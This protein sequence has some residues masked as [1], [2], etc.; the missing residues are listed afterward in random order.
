M[1][2]FK[3]PLAVYFVWHPAD[4]KVVKPLVDYCVDQFIRN[5]DNPFSRGI[6]LPIFLCSSRDGSTPNS[7]YDKAQK[8]IIVPFVGTEVV[9]DDNWKALYESL[10]NSDCISIIP[11]AIDC[12]GLNLGGRLHSL[13]CLRAKDWG[14][15]YVNEKAFIAIAHEIF[16]YSFSPLK[17][18]K[19]NGSE[20]SINL[21]ISHSKWGG[22]GEKVAREIKKFI[23]NSPMQSFFDAYEI[24]PGQRFDDSIVEKVK[25][26]TLIAIHTDSYSSRYW[27]QKEIM[28]AKESSRPIIAVDCQDKFEDRRFPHSSNIPSTHIHTAD[29]I[30]EH[31]VLQIL[32]SAILET[33]R[34]SYCL[35]LLEYYKKIGW[36]SADSTVLAKPLELTD[37]KKLKSDETLKEFVY[38]E[39]PLYPEEKEIIENLSAKSYTPLEVLAQG[40]SDLSVGISISESHQDDLL[41]YGIST[42]HLKILSQD[43]ARHLLARKAKLI[44]GGDLRKDGFTQ[45]IIEEAEALQI[46]LGSDDIYV[47]NYLAWPIY[48]S[49][50]PKV[51]CWKAQFHHI[52]KMHQLE[53]PKDIQDIIPADK[54]SIAPCN[55]QNN[56]AWSRSLTEMRHTSIERSD[57]RICAGGRLDGYKGKMPGVLEEVMISMEKEKPLFLLG[58]FGGITSTVCK[59][60]QEGITSPEL[61]KDWQA[62]HTGGYND[63][64]EFAEKRDKRYLANYDDIV[65]KLKNYDLSKLSERNGLTNEENIRLFNTSF[66]DEAL[67]LVLKGIEKINEK[68]GEENV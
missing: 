17:D 12:C 56:Y 67:H 63:L 13:H 11:I 26:S 51:K 18:K 1:T 27:C 58:G 57:I 68:M 39:P 4:T 55:S 41:N 28:I 35:E 37:L 47:E 50:S 36:V 8:N 34:Y 2:E 14:G 5:A 3:P 21:F 24:M 65:N 9:A 60:I 7:T 45:F 16:R 23:D 42:K 66:I 53:P 38:P 49:D 54:S 19:A 64:L 59:V 10:P 33:I 15:D 32:K 48:C 20:S 30:S 22:S 44:Y 6:D 61:T 52:L 31:D 43:L 29:K 62:Y 25:Q 46:R 40:L